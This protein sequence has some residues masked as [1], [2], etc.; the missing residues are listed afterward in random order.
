MRGGEVALRA[1]QRSLCRQGGAGE[2]IELQR[3]LDARTIVRCHPAAL[4]TH[5]RQTGRVA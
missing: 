5:S 2:A 1:Q 4:P 3:E